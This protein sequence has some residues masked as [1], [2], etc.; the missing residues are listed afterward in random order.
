M[1]HL[2]A[3]DC[4]VFSYPPEIIYDVLS[5]IPEYKKWWPRGVR[6]KV[7]EH[8]KDRIGDKIEVW[9]SGGWFRC[10]V[11]ALQPIE[12]IEIMYYAGVVLGK[13]YWTIIPQQDGMTKVCYTIDLELNGTFPKLIGVFINFSA[14]H[15]FQFRRVLACLDNYLRKTVQT[16]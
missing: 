12:Q 6:V 4:R 8:G 5:N 9:A 15:S 3:K 14:I 7:I 2:S 13:S 11:N 1:Q 16:K 10:R